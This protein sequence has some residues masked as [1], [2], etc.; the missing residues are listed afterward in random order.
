MFDCLAG[1]SDATEAIDTE[2]SDGNATTVDIEPLLSLIERTFGF[3]IPNFVEKFMM[4]QAQIV[5][6][7]ALS[8]V[9]GGS[10]DAAG[11]PGTESEPPSWKRNMVVRAL[12]F[13]YKTV[14]G[15][16]MPDDVREGLKS[17]NPK[18]LN[19]LITFFAKQAESP[20]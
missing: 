18:S 13:A 19:F 12:G 11:A 8:K 6:S 10:D 16:A 3:D 9:L 20:S 2:Q 5:D 1:K 17:G 4:E 7:A 15:T 14:S